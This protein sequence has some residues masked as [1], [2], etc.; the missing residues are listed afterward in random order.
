M[1][2]TSAP[3]DHDGLMKT[4]PQ[5]KTL[6]ENA[7]LLALVIVICIFMLS[8]IRGRIAS[9]LTELNSALQPLP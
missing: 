1:P 6:I 7:L 3:V 4:N 5:S 9:R 8:S 2:F